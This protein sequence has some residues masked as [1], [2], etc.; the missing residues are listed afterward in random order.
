MTLDRVTIPAFVVAGASL[1]VSAFFHGN[2]AGTVGYGCF[3][4]LPL[5][6]IAWPEVADAAFRHSWSGF[7]HGGEGPTPAPPLRVAAWALLLTVIV[8]HH[9]MAFRGI[10]RV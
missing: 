9:F 2:L 1:V 6:V 3:M 4:V 5:S 10:A 7:T 8:V